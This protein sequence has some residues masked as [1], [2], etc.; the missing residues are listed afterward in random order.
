MT[1]FKLIRYTQRVRQGREEG[2]VEKEGELIKQLKNCKQEWTAERMYIDIADAMT[3]E[4]TIPGA[5][6]YTHKHTQSQS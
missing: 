1:F 2:R 6:T 4:C 3:S 5:H